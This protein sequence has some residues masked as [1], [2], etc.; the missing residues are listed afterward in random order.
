MLSLASVTLNSDRLSDHLLEAATLHEWSSLA[1][2][3]R[4]VSCPTNQTQNWKHASAASASSS[5][6]TLSVVT[7]AS[8]PLNRRRKCGDA[9]SILDILKGLGR[10]SL[11]GDEYREAFHDLASKRVNIST[12]SNDVLQGLRGGRGRYL[13]LT[14]AHTTV[15]ECHCL[16]SP[17]RQPV[18]KWTCIRTWST[19]RLWTLTSMG[20]QSIVIDAEKYFL[21]R[22]R[23][24]ESRRET[25]ALWKQLQLRYEVWN[26]V[27]A[28]DAQELGYYLAA[29]KC[30]IEH[31]ARL[32]RFSKWTVASCSVGQSPCCDSMLALPRNWLIGVES[33]RSWQ[34]LPPSSQTFTNFH[35]R[36]ASTVCQWKSLLDSVESSHCGR[37]CQAQ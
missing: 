11:E 9:E 25:A 6:I 16:T 32:D 28:P 26:G 15:W 4:R 1:C 33:R 20:R 22:Y 21:R 23:E 5:S 36:I 7:Q 27:D 2:L 19:T 34:Q 13:A 29:C 18:P 37:R 31:P 35:L 14:P 3:H 24:K 17:L 10:E 8:R 12:Q 30:W